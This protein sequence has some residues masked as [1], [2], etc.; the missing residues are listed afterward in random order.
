MSGRVT[1]HCPTRFRLETVD[2]PQKPPKIGAKRRAACDCSAGSQVVLQS[3]CSMGL[4]APTGLGSV[5]RRP[6]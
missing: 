4:S 1:W 3:C 5:W 6:V 2:T